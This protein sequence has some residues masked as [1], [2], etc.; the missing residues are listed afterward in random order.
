MNVSLAA[1]GL[2][3]FDVFARKGK[4]GWV[5]QFTIEAKSLEQA[6]ERAL[7]EDPSFRPHMITAY[8]KK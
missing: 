5:Y 1:T 7:K 3:Q 2:K 8:P 6:K 4:A